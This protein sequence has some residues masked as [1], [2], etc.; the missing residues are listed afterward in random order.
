ML[1]RIIAEK[2]LKA[3][4]VYGFFPAASLGDDIV[5]YTDATRS[6]E[7]ARFHMLREQWERKA[8]AGTAV[9]RSLADYV[10]PVETSLPD[11]IGAFAVTAGEGAE[12]LDAYFRAKLDDYQGIMAK[13]IADRLAEAFA[14]YLHM[15]AR[16]QWYAPDAEKMSKEDL[17]RERYEGIRPAAG[18]PSCP[19]HTEKATLWNLLEAEKNTGMT[20]TESFS[21]V[22][23]ASVSGLYFGH[24]K[25]KYFAI[26][27]LTRDQIQDYARR[28]GIPQ[29]DAE[30]WLQS[31]LGYDPA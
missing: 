30:K 15:V 5:L 24:S 1:D 16:A 18:Y 26:D 31:Y 14:E 10:A 9:F 19:D 17:I 25:A 6:N 27:L 3:R 21:M 13:A 20:L 8:E 12:K 4:G 23:A 22:P 29:S 2:A 11:H 28:K 7:L